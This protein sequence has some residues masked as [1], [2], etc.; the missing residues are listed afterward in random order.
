L[1]YAAACDVHLA[2][3]HHNQVWSFAFK[4]AIQLNN[5]KPILTKTIA[6]P[7]NYLP[8]K[9]HHIIFPTSASLDALLMFSKRT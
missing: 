1:N 6:A 5:M 4:H 8:E 3:N 2:Q 9:H 7:T